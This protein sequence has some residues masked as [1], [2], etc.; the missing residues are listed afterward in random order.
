MSWIILSLIF[1]WTLYTWCF[2]FNSYLS[3]V[4]F[5]SQHAR[6]PHQNNDKVNIDSIIVYLTALK[7]REKS[8]L[9]FHQTEILMKASTNFYIIC[10]LTLWW[11]SKCSIF[12]LTVIGTAEKKLQ[13]KKSTV[14]LQLMESFWH[15]YTQTPDWQK[16][17]DFQSRRPCDERRGTN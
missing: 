13:M 3:H 5:L 4:V 8:E 6:S 11:V 2:S 16:H 7:Q 9:H 12:C 14:D 15:L 1:L 10:I 17:V